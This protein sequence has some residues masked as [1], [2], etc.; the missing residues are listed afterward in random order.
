MG[1]RDGDEGDAMANILVAEDNKNAN[2]LIC[3]VLRRQG[4]EAISAYDGREALDAFDEHHVDLLIADVMMPRMDGTEL[5]RRLRDADYD[6][7]I[8]MLTAK[9]AQEDKNAGLMAGADDYLTKPANM[10]E[11]VLRVRSLLRRAGV[12][13]ERRLEVGRVVLDADALAVVRGTEEVRLP[14]KEF[15]LLQFLLQNPGRTYTRMQLLDEIWGWDTESAERTVDVHV[16]RLRTRFAGWE[17]FSI[18]TIRGLGYRAM[19]PGA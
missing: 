13:D 16:N 1:A 17:E 9:G 5:V 11:L 12:R 19:V 6:L 15:R 8:L 10:Q 2:K 14:P 4:H 18:E 7:P 3:T